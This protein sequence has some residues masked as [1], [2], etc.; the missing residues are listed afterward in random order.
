MKTYGEY[1]DS[2]VEWLGE[3]P[4]HWAIVPCRAIVD[5]IA[6]KNDDG[7]IKNYLSLVANVG[8]IPYEEKGDV[9]NKKPDDLSKCKIVEK[10]NLV[11][12]SMNYAIGSY[13]MSNYDGICSPVYIVLNPKTPVVEK[14]FSLRVFE[15][16]PLQKHLSLLGNGIL[17]HRAAIK[18]DDIKSQS[19]PLPPITE[20]Q[21]ILRYLDR[22]TARIDQL[23]TEKQNFIKLLKEKRQ[24]LISHVV[25]KGLD[26]T[27]KMKDSG[28]EWIG[29]VPEGWVVKK[30]KSNVKTI[31]QGW[32]PQCE[33]T[34]VTDGKSWAVVKVGCV[35]NGVFN[36]LQNKKLPDDLEPKT[37]Y[38]IKKGD[39]LI[40]RANSKEWVGS[41]AVP[42][43]EHPNL[44][45]CDKLYCLTLK[46]RLASPDFIAY[47][48]GSDRAR[49]QIEI[50][51][52]G[53]SSSM[54]NIGQSTILDMP[55]AQPNL[56]EQLQIV[57]AIRTQ[58]KIIE[59]LMSEVQF[60]INLIQEHRTALIS[61]AVTG[62]IDVRDQ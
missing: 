39:L 12:N 41:A 40:S 49:G 19:I 7:E 5:N 3:V 8:V 26:P 18:W 44:I 27:V 50:D 1:K 4:K 52:T 62:K 53:T 57:D 21:G 23:I 37:E 35:N 55:I 48:L 34:R 32:S 42:Q 20:Q 16:K 56:D 60:S 14:R 29:E 6:R 47:F 17:E 10:G 43:Q 28:V 13:G 46:P 22:E 24:A 59:R 11:I 2:G 36:P 61:A 31:S 15:N 51:A 33:S 9:G 30:I 58:T 38:A 25:T 54:L 45:L